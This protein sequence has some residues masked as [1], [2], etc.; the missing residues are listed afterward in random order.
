[1]IFHGRMAF[2]NVHSDANRAVV[3][4]GDTL[5]VASNGTVF[6]VTSGIQKKYSEISYV[7]EDNQEDEPVP[8]KAPKAKNTAK[9]SKSS[10]GSYSEENSDSLGADDKELIQGAD[11]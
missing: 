9:A 10:S 1:M 2:T 8:E 5:K 11:D 6:E 4:V 3:A 7:L